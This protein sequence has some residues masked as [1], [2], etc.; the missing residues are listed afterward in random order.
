MSKMTA[1]GGFEFRL[2]EI[3]ALQKPRA[4]SLALGM[5]GRAA[6]FDSPLSED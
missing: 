3:P 6:R 5:P 2:I 4:K 1:E